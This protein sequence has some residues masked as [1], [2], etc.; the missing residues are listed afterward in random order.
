[1]QVLEAV[2]TVLVEVRLS[3]AGMALFH[4]VSSARPAFSK[5]WQEESEDL[6]REAMTLAHSAGQVIHSH[7]E[8]KMC[9]FVLSESLVSLACCAGKCFTIT[10]M[11]YRLLTQILLT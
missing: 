2:S 5:Q 11:I 9:L 3:R 6:L 4:P 1:M 8:I 7:E 10:R